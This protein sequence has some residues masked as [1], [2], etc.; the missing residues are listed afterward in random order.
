MNAIT[1]AEAV[2]LSSLTDWMDTEQL[3][4]GEITNTRLLTG[5]SQ[6]IL[7][8]F[9]RAVATLCPCSCLL[10]MYFAGSRWSAVRWFRWR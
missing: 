10:L 5:G 8:Q 2:D 7:M 6:N 9:D 4:N 3:G 1:A